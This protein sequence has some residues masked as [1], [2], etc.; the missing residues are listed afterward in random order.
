[1]ENSSNTNQNT[2]QEDDDPEGIPVPDCVVEDL[3]ELSDKSDTPL[4]VVSQHIQFPLQP[5]DINDLAKLAM[6]FEN[7]DDV[8][9]LS[10]PQLGI[11]KRAIMFQVKQASAEEEDQTQQ[12]SGSE[13]TADEIEATNPLQMDDIHIFDELQNKDPNV[14]WPKTLWINPSYTIPRDAV[15]DEDYEVCYSLKCDTDFVI[16]PVFRVNRLN[17]RAYDLLGRIL[18]GQAE[19]EVARVIQ[20]EIDHLDG[21]LYIDYVQPEKVMKLPQYVEKTESGE[22][23]ELQK[24][25]VPQF[26]N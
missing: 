12:K 14:I 11:N 23:L 22:V 1:M 9:G 21:K 6:R 13:P 4:R 19:G 8:M 15:L 5:D 7:M 18:E 2:V 10:L 16:A 24:G 3:R 20:H 25:I 26:K 17:Y